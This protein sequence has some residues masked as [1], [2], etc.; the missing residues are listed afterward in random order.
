[1]KPFI[2]SYSKQFLNFFDSTDAVNLSQVNKQTDSLNR[3]IY[4][5]NNSHKIT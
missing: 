1:M 5:D 4:L 3:L 2:K